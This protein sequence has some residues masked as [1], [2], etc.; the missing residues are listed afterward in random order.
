MKLFADVSQLK[1]TLWYSSIYGRY[2]PEKFCPV[3]VTQRTTRRL[4]YM[5][6]IL[7]RGNTK[8]TCKNLDFLFDLTCNSRV[9]Y[10]YVPPTEIVTRVRCFEEVTKSVPG[11]VDAF[12]QIAPEFPTRRRGK[13]HERMARGAA[14]KFGRPQS[15]TYR[16]LES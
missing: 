7:F 1:Q 3:V 15:Y 5:E 13:S 4:C 8:S 2:P 12:A 11:T 14:A 6:I 10:C 9:Y 16:V